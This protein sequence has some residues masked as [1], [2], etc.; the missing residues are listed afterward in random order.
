MFSSR[1]CNSLP[2]FHLVYFS[3]EDECSQVGDNI[4][5]H[6]QKK[7]KTSF[8]RKFV[9][10]T[11][12]GHRW[13]VARPMVRRTHPLIESESPTNSSLKNLTKCQTRTDLWSV[14][15]SMVRIM[16]PLINI[17]FNQSLT[18]TMIYQY[19]S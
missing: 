13:T 10:T 15:Q 1:V 6:M 17:P 7:Q 12:G 16:C 19:G 5:P 8:F 11:D 2:L 18:C 4:I 3:F 14:G 9:G